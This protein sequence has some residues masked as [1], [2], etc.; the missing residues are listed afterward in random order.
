MKTV[1]KKEVI[2]QRLSFW[3]DIYEKYQAAYIALVESGVKYYMV[4]DRQLSK[5]EILDVQENIEKA[6]KMIDYYQSL[7]DGKAARKAFGIIPREW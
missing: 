6:E 7:L 1:M 5:F 2:R 3:T 4:D